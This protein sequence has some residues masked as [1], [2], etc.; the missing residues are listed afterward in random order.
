MREIPEQVLREIS[1]D[2]RKYLDEDCAN[3]IAQYFSILGNLF[4]SILAPKIKEIEKSIPSRK[5]LHELESELE[6]S[7]QQLNIPDLIKEKIG[8]CFLKLLKSNWIQ[9]EF[10]KIIKSTI[11]KELERLKRYR[12]A[13][14]LLDIFHKACDRNLKLVGIS[15]HNHYQTEQFEEFMYKLFDA[16]RSLQELAKYEEDF[17]IQFILIQSSFKILSEAYYRRLISFLMDC[18]LIIE[19]GEKPKAKI[20][21]IGE[22]YTDFEK[23]KKKY[24]NAKVFFNKIVKDIRNSFA[25]ADYEIDVESKEIIIKE[26]GKILYRLNNTQI[27]NELEYLVKMS[28]IFIYFYFYSLLYLA[29]KLNLWKSVLEEIMKN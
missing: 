21:F 12:E 20:R 26:R 15:W 23:Y 3:L 6:K 28:N 4:A 2:L 11:S 8:D 10:P 27:G 18:I 5:T 29:E 9:E 16:L 24:P 7:A 17:E 25:H 22:T 19:E 14:T 13:E 1:R